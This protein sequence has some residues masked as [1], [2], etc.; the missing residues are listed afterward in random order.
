MD[1]QQVR[2]LVRQA[3]ARHL[4]GAPD[5]APPPVRPVAPV[6]AAGFDV[7]PP[8]PTSHVSVAKFHLVRPAGETECVIEPTVTC[9]HCGHCLCYGH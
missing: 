5:P 7:V 6:I 4:G 1:E 3:I 9:N 2:Q 8:T